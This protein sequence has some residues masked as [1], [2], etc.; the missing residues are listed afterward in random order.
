MKNIKKTIL[1]RKS[2]AKRFYTFNRVLQNVFSGRQID[3]FLGI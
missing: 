1:P 2:T 3:S